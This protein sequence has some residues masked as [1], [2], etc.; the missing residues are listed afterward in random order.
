MKIDAQD[1]YE[2]ADDPDE[3]PVCGKTGGEWKKIEY[4]NL[5]T[6]LCLGCY[7]DEYFWKDMY[8]TLHVS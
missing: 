3:C 1:V 8:I 4:P 5:L 2:Y 6:F 7:H